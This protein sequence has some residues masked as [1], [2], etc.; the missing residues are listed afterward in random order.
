MAVGFVYNAAAQGIRV[1]SLEFDSEGDLDLHGFLGLRMFAPVTRIFPLIY[2]SRA[3]L[4]PKDR[5]MRVCAAHLP[6]IGYPP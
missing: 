2:G 5:R 1:E 3:T 4:P 6:G